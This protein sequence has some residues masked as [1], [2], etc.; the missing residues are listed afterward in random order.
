MDTQKT[1]FR[2]AYIGNFE[3]E[4]STENDVRK[5]FEH[6]GHEVVCIQE[7]KTPWA[8]VRDVALN[9]DMLLW[10][11]TW[12]EENG[13]Q[14]LK[15]SLETL[16][17]CALAGIPTAAYHLDVFFGSD[18]GARRWL[19]NPMF[20]VRHLFTASADHQYQWDKIG[21]NHKWLRP[22]I[23]HD[24]AHFGTFR[25]EYACDVA[26]LGSNGIG[27]HE[28][29]WPY[30]RQLILAL[31]EMCQR[32]GWKWRNPGGELDKPNAGKIERNEDRN[33]FY[34]SARV[35]VGDSL[36]LLKEKSL[37]CSDR[38]YE[39][40]GCGGLLI[41]PQI[42]FVDQDFEH[43]MAMYQ[44][45]NFN[46][47]EKIIRVY[48]EDPDLRRKDREA[49]QKITAENHTYVNRAQTILKEVGLA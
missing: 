17:L 40:T 19:V 34:A 14:P 18:R 10:T 8:T 35:T 3:P 49:C 1:K 23:R 37:Y 36:C 43:N 33:D 20:F 6:L 4:W 9:S 22:G 48:M 46:H 31:E 30:R 41:M 2:I 47:L 27:Y 7:D 25:D 12:E 21:V 15:E 32:N 29:A 28:S 16:R 13:G 44:W 26:F 24:A 39:A 11:T 38:V 45:G 42:D 5:A